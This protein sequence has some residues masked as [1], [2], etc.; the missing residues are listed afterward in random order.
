MREAG[1]QLAVFGRRVYNARSILFSLNVFAIAAGA[2]A[3]TYNY[4]VLGRLTSVTDDNGLTT[5]YVFDAAGNRSAVS[6]AG[7][8]AAG[9]I[10]LLVPR[11]SAAVGV[12]LVVNGAYSTVA[13]ITAP[14]HGTATATG[15][16]ITYKPASGYAGADSFTYAASNGSTSSAPATVSV[17]V[18]PRANNVTSGFTVAYGS[19]GNVAPIS[20]SGAYTAAAIAILPGNGNAGASGTAITYTPAPGYFG[21]DTFEYVASNAGATS[22]PATMS[23]TVNP[24][25]P[26]VA[27]PTSPTVRVGTV[28]NLM[29]LN[30]TGGAPVSIG[31]A[32]GAAHGT[33][34]VSGLNILYTPV[35][36]YSGAD[37]FGYTAT[38]AGGASPSAAVSITVTP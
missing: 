10:S 7:T 8:P 2:N 21:S 16:S 19:T 37:S 31:I 34:S 38:N 29:P 35:A 26:P 1:G 28:N 13:V 3:A 36:G 11:N 23:V 4:D 33:A 24:P 20:V 27:N 32:T 6:I 15:L 5:A 9:Q 22:A 12:P 18:A 25:P 17:G 14:S 30:I